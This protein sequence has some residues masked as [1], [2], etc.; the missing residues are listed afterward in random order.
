MAEAI[1]FTGL[2][3]SG[4][5]TYFEKHFAKTHAHISR[6]VVGTPDLESA[7]V[8]DYLQSRPLFCRGQYKRH[9]SGTCSLYTSSKGRGVRNAFLLFRCAGADGHW[10]EQSPKR[11]EADSG[12]RDSPRSETP[13]AAHN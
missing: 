9:P 7:L 13:G 5:T 6:D 4:K 1:I 11:Q 2:Q 10:T 12:S 3:G 8:R